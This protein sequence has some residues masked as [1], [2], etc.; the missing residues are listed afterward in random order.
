MFSYCL[1]RFRLLRS[2][3]M[4]L[5]RCTLRSSEQSWIR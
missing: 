2:Y 1:I 4:N 5:I 3:R